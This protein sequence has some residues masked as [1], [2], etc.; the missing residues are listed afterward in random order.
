MSDMRDNIA[1]IIEAGKD[2]IDPATEILDLIHSE[3]YENTTLPHTREVEVDCDECKG[4]W[5]VYHNSKI[6]CMGCP[7]ETAET[8][9]PNIKK[10]SGACCIHCHKCKGTGKRTV[11]ET[12]GYTCGGCGG[13]GEKQCCNCP[14]GDLGLGE[15]ACVAMGMTPCD[16]CPTCSGSG[17]IPVTKKQMLD[18]EVEWK[19]ERMEDP[20]HPNLPILLNRTQP[21]LNGQPCKW[22]VL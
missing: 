14:D 20:I 4:G 10:I 21:Y 6:H 11:T 22:R 17:F 15:Q 18:G 12:L 3:G 1:E 19:V 2:I 16:S 9:P 7:N 5:V 8:C 13:S